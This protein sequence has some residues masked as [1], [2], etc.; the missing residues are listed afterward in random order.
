[1]TA[2]LFSG[3]HADTAELSRKNGGHA[4]LSEVVATQLRELIVAGKLKPGQFLRIDAIAKMLGVSMTPVREGLLLLQSESFVRLLPRRGFV[5]NSFSKGDVLDLFWAQA[6]IAAELASR[7]ASAISEQEID[8]LK[9]LHVA[10]EAAVATGA[11]DRDRLG[12]EFHRSINLAANSPRL[13]LMLGSLT[14]QLP[15]RF[16][17]SIEGQLNS[18]LDFHPLILK[19]IQLRDGET[20]GS[21]MRRH[22]YGGGEHLVEMLE[23]QGLWEDENEKSTEAR[24]PVASRK[25]TKPGKKKKAVPRAKASKR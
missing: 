15:N 19:S 9:Q 10:Y 8:R 24:K 1:M 4:Q 18:A 11:A 20:A 2:L 14:R 21:L 5:V 25:P 13:A 7:A 23:R 3:G 12:H 16:Y 22:I 17:A 6:V